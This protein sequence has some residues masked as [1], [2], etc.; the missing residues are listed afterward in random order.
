MDHDHSFKNLILDYPR[1]A[2][3]FFAPQVAADLPADAVFTPIREEQLKERLGE[4][5][6][7]LDTPVEVSFPSGERETIVFDV[8]EHTR[9]GTFEIERLAHYCLDISVLRTTRRVVPVVIFLR[10]G[11]VEKE[12]RIGIEHHEF[13]HFRY[14][15]CDLSRLEAARFTDSSNIVARLNLPNMAH[16]A[17][18]R[19]DVYDR[20]LQ[21]LAQFE[22]NPNRRRK[23]LDFVEQYARLTTDERLQWKVHHEKEPGMNYW[24]ELEQKAKAEGKAEGAVRVLLDFV[25]SGL[26]TIDAARAEFERLVAAGE[27]SAALADEARRRLALPH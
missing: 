8:E 1:E 27:V 17:E 12:L 20:A 26:L 25:A 14:I 2:L 13:L 9:P 19:V 24:A 21:G 10:A 15:A 23:Y 22:P 7:E 3:A 5:F 18:A 4:R 16:P 6:R 11:E